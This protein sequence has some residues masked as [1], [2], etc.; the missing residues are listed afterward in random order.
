MSSNPFYPEMW[1][2]TLALHALPEELV[3]L[4]SGWAA[5]HD[6]YVAVE[7]FSPT[8]AAAAVPLAGDITTAMAE[9]APVRR[10]ALRRG[11][12]D[13]QA[14]NAHQHL[15][16]NP[17][18]LAMVLEPLTDDGL[19]ATALTLRMGDQELLRWWIALVREAATDMHR[20]A[21]ALDPDG[22]GRMP[23]PDHF[24][25]RGAHDLAARGVAMRAATGNALFEFHDLS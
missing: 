24:H 12:F 7:R 20:G 25:T 13:V 3:G 22:G 15:D 1:H 9:L 11:V 4:A 5:E 14:I 8:Y 6:L 23:V 18:S 19:R 21:T 2:F 10:I 17:E 16:R